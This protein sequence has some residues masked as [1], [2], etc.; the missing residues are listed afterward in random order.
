MTPREGKTVA[1]VEPVVEAVLADVR[2]G[3][4][5]DEVDR[6]VRNILAQKLRGLERIGGFGGKADL[7]D[8]YEM[9]TG[10]P[11]YVQKD[12]AR[13]Q[14]VTPESVKA[15]AQKYLDPNRRLILDTEPAAKTADAR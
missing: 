9:W 6:A 8:A 2:N 14:A 13:Y 1:D 7:L 5:Q 15:F 12:L 11:G 4:T 3:V 10:D